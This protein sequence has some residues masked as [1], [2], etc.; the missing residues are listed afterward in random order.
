M[1]ER[2]PDDRLWCVHT[3][4]PDE[5][6]PCASAQDAILLANEINGF[7]EGHMVAKDWGPNSVIA[8]ARPMVWKGSAKDHAIAL[9]E[10]QQQRIEHFLKRIGAKEASDQ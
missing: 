3:W 8:W 5:I 9:T 1:S 4:G 6:C 2:T 10:H 7:F